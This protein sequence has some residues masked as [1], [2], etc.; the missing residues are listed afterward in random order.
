MWL[1]HIRLSL[2]IHCYGRCSSNNTKEILFE[3]NYLDQRW[4]VKKAYYA[5]F[6][7]DYLSAHSG[8]Q[9]TSYYACPND[10]PLD[11]LLHISCKSSVTFRVFLQVERN[12]F[13]KKFLAP[14]RSNVDAKKLDIQ[15]EEG[16]D[17]PTPLYNHVLSTNQMYGSGEEL[18][19]D[20]V[21]ESDVIKQCM[22]LKNM[23]H[24]KRLG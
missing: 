7:L 14:H 18:T 9:Y 24:Q 2:K 10:N 12:A 21:K 13:L 1:I 17:I 4:L 8:D 3:K 6:L 19:A 22:M 20:W 16:V 11:I 23:M 5:A 15:V